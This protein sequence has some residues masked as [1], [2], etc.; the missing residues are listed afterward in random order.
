MPKHPKTFFAHIPD[1]PNIP[2]IINLYT[3][4]EGKNM[5][6]QE[7]NRNAQ[8]FTLS[9][10]INLNEEWTLGEIRR[11]EHLRETQMSI[12]DIAKELGRSYYSVSNKLATAGLTTPR[13]TTPA[14]KAV[15]CQTCFTTPS[16]SGAC[17]C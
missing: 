1:L 5:Q 14:P 12:R 9:T 4:T 3:T 8:S 13:N 15:V 17:L 11:M 7:W 6:T 2:D 10:A 16:N